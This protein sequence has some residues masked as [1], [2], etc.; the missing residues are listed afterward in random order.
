MRILVT[1]GAGYIGS[2]TVRH[3]L[4]RGHQVTVLDNLSEG[5]PA[6]VPAECLHVGDLKDADYLDHLLLIH[7]IE[8]VIHFAA[9]AYVG[10]SITDPAKYYKN[11]LVYSLMLLEHVRRHGIR[12]FVFSS[13]CA[14]YGVP[15]QVPISE[16]EPQQPINP[17][18]QTKLAFERAL[19]DYAQAYGI[20]A[21]ALR[22]FNAAGAAADGSIGEDHDPE[23]HLIPLVLQVALGQ[24]PRVDI[25]GTDYPTPDGTCIRDYI[26]VEDLAAAHALALEQIPP[27]AWRAYNVGIGQGSSV[28]EVIRLA[29]KVTSKTIPFQECPRRPG[30]PPVLIADAQKIRQELGWQPRFPTLQ[31]MIETAWRWHQSHPT[32]YPQ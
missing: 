5:H 17:Y 15:H 8:A 19:A 10:E 28:R 16:L 9:C 21:V 13:S 20:G 2:H 14:T 4:N 32:G 25:Y 31:A 6:A 22:Y 11:N 26:H 24:R 29:E 23:T 18:G 7:R 12:K 3:L 30:D 27:G 1:G